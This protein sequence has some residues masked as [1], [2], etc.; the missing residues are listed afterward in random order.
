MQCNLLCLIACEVLLLHSSIWD[1][2]CSPVRHCS[3]TVA[4]NLPLSLEKQESIHSRLPVTLIGRKLT[5][6]SSVLQVYAA[7][8]QDG[9]RAVV[10]LNRH[11]FATQYP[12]SNITVDW[13][14]LGFPKGSKVMPNLSIT[15]SPNL[16]FS[17][18]LSKSLAT[19]H[20]LF[21]AGAPRASQRYMSFV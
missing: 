13:S 3:S 4:S 5:L 21:Q 1:S 15:A 10:I 16:L 20:R 19:H 12:L 11:T 9:T 17:S 7:P 6:S 2:L 8:L 18:A 14:W